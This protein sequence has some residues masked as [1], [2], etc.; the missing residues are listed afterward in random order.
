MSSSTRALVT[1]A[2]GCLGEQLVQ[3]LVET[4][5]SVRALARQSSRTESLGAL[6]VSVERG[7]LTDEADL[8]RA[9]KGMDVVYHLGG[10]VIDDPSDTSDAL[11]QQIREVNV[12]GTEKLARQAAAAGVRRFV[13]ASSVRIFGFGNQILWGEDG[14][15]TPSD[16]YSR[17]KALAEEA[18]ARVAQET[19]LEV[20]NIRPRFIYGN[21]DR[22]ILPRIV[23]QIQRGVAPLPRGGNALCDTVYVKDCVQGFMLAAEQPVAGRSYNIVSGE[24]L[25]FREIFEEVARAMGR[26]VRIVPLPGPVATGIATAVEFGS[27]ALHRAPALSRAQLMWYMNDHSFSIARARSELGY[28]PRYRLPDAL[29][30]IDLQKFAAAA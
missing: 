4:G 5:V 28:Q 18:L 26:T 2:T 11:W 13:F 9:V 19:G 24:C 22:Y 15:R 20:V 14:P 21:G 27:R 8:Q 29:R 25:T 3:S 30:E 23:Q 10:L 17:G 16:L 7:S 12:E 1:G 6:G